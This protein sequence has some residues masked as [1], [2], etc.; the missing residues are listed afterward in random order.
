MSA[1]KVTIHSTGV[2]MCALTQKEG[3]GLAVSMDDG[4]V[5]E[6]FL[7]W[8]AFRQLLAMKATQGVKPEAKPE[9]KPAPP[10]AAVLAGNGPAK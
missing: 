10:L 3:D 4:T 9:P 7:S 2:G 8:K 1:I 5:R 6:Q